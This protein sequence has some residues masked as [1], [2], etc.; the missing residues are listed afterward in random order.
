MQAIRET[1]FKSNLILGVQ[2]EVINLLKTN[3]P[4]KSR[5]KLISSFNYNKLNLKYTRTNL[6][7]NLLDKSSSN[8]LEKHNKLIT[9]YCVILELLNLA[10][11]IHDIVNNN[12]KCSSIKLT[13]NLSPAQAILV[14]DLIFTI[15]FEQ[16]LS[17]NNIEIQNHF[18]STTEQMALAQ[19]KLQSYTSLKHEESNHSLE[20]N[21]LFNKNWPLFNSIIF[22]FEEYF[23][24]NN[25]EVIKSITDDVHQS[26]IN[27]SIVKS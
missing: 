6:L 14:G 8:N 25:S 2:K 15:A 3:S 21:L 1:R 20:Q 19:A 10:S 27:Y 12:N 17:L 18:A 24:L 13:L 23:K 9:T 22:L 11:K 16:I 5:L 4:F 7:V 26:C